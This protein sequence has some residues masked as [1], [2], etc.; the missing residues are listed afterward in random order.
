MWNIDVVPYIIIN[1]QKMH[2]NCIYIKFCMCKMGKEG[3]LH[4]NTLGEDWREQRCAILED[5]HANDF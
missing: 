5:N 3:C 2:I 4:E 1:I